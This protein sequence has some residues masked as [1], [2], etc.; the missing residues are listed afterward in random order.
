M[1]LYFFKLPKAKKVRVFIIGVKITSPNLNDFLFPTSKEGLIIA[2]LEKFKVLWRENCNFHYFAFQI[3]EFQFPQL[4][5]Q[6]E[7]L[8]LF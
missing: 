1:G 6:K 4:S 8:E 3:F 5:V 7:Y 2:S